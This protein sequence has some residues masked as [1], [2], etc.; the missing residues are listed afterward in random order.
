MTSDPGNCAQIEPEEADRIPLRP[1][2]RR[3]CT[4]WGCG[5]LAVPV[6]LGGFILIGVGLLPRIGPPSP[7][8]DRQL[9]FVV[10]CERAL[11]EKLKFPTTASISSAWEDGI[12]NTASGFKWV[13][14]TE[15]EE[16][17][18]AKIKTTFSCSG[19]ADSPAIE[20]K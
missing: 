9:I 4:R 10:N 1:E 3:G 15:I 19:P 12:L 13:G 14:H 18:G 8:G 11:K 20:I 7:V 5:L 17:S 16:N 2:R 6:I